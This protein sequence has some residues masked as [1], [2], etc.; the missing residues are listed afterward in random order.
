MNSQV[1]GAKKG[2]NYPMRGTGVRSC[3]EGG[4]IPTQGANTEWDLGGTNVAPDGG[5]GASEFAAFHEEMAAR[6]ADARAPWAKAKL[7]I[8]AI[9]LIQ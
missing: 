1:D 9:P 5:A 2:D 3:G 8:S 6:L 7:F 4:Y